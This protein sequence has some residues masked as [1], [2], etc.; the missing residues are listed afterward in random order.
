M[1]KIPKAWMWSREQLTSLRYVHIWVVCVPVH[2][3]GEAVFRV[4]NWQAWCLCM[5][6][7]IALD[8]ERNNP[9]LV[10]TLFQSSVKPKNPVY[11]WMPELEAQEWN[12]L[13]LHPKPCLLLG[14]WPRHTCAH[15]MQLVTETM[16]TAG[17]KI[18]DCDLAISISAVTATDTLTKVC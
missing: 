7:S 10:Y 15:T 16:R 8:D 18:K 9:H 3:G 2:V 13:N 14:D 11:C 12:S 17:V 4:S 6:G 5:L 1:S